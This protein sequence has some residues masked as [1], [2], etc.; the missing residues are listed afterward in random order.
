[1]LRK[2]LLGHRLS[3]PQHRARSRRPSHRQRQH[4]L[5]HAFAPL[6]SL[7]QIASYGRITA[8][9]TQPPSHQPWQHAPS[10]GSA[11]PFVS[12]TSRAR[13]T[14]HTRVRHAPPFRQRPGS[15]PFHRRLPTKPSTPGSARPSV[16]QQAGPEPLRTRGFGTSLRFVNDQGLNHFAH[17]CQRNPQSAFVTASPH[18]AAVATLNFTSSREHSH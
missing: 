5:I 15:Q 6:L 18:D 12:P 3:R 7:F 10:P 16:S 1:M 13:I 2:H 17:A 4:N 9:S 11:R 8:T 14:S